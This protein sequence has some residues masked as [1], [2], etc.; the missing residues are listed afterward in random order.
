MAALGHKACKI[1]AREILPDFDQPE[2]YFVPA[3][4]S[5]SDAALPV[6]RQ[7]CIVKTAC[8]D[9]SPV[10]S[11][12]A[13]LDVRDDEK[14]DGYFLRRI[15]SCPRNVSSS[16]CSSRCCCCFVPLRE[17]PRS[18]RRNDL[19]RGDGRK[20]SRHPNA[21]VTVRNTETNVART[22]QTD[23][24]AL[25]LRERAGRGYEMTVES[26]GF[27]KYVR[28]GITSRSTTGR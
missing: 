18:Q 13:H 16:S 24:A 25:P 28:S 22:A 17:R 6:I 12:V 7:A 14:A 5:V 1:P 3:G 20:G 8:G 11:K 23:A 10:G 21:T 27:A 19:R 26:G 2:T 15:K 9:S 4:R